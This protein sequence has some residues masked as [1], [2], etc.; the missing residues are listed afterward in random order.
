MWY[1]LPLLAGVCIALSEFCS[2]Y[3][4]D[5]Q[6]TVEMK[7]L[8][9]NVLGMLCSLA[10]MPLEQVQVSFNPFAIG[11][12]LVNGG[13]MAIAGTLYY[14]GLKHIDISV[15]TVL[16]KTSVL[17]YTLG[18]IFL[19][20][21][22]LTVLQIAGTALVILS[23]ASINGLGTLKKIKLNT[24][25]S[26]LLVTGCLFGLSILSDNYLS[27]YFSPFFY[28]FSMF[29][30]TSII[31]SV[32][33]VLSK[34]VAFSAP[35]QKMLLTQLV[36]AGLSVGGQALLLMTYRLGGYVSLSNLFAL[37]RLP[38]VLI[39]GIIILKER[40]NIQQKLISIAI[41]TAGLILLKL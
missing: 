27:Q 2:K 16:T 13:L 11:L 14:V 3:I 1:I 24:W 10:L 23:L 41:L 29:T 40:S 37:I 26:I 30:T 9:A 7:I 25:A 34:R 4:A 8:L 12:L 22:Q 21:E 33:Y 38:L 15:S 32:Y 28:L 31:L 19:M 5:D 35:K 17:V 6:S 20:G 18:G 36:A 39:F